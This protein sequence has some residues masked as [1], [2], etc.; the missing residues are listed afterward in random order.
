M[1]I[2]LMLALGLLGGFVAIIMVV[3]YINYAVVEPM[4]KRRVIQQRIRSSKKGKDFRTQI[5]K[6][7]Q[8]SSQGP[9]IAI[10][11]RLTGWSKAESLQRQLLQGDIYISPGVFIC[12]VGISGALG[13]LFSSK[14]QLGF[15]DPII[16]LAAGYVPFMLLHWKQKRKTAKFEKYMPDAME[17]LAR[18]LRA[19]HTL[20]ST[21]E[22][23]SQEI[24][25]PL[26]KEMRITY[27]E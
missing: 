12:V 6:A 26:G 1:N 22:L 5:F 18:S 17:L 10:I 27:E 15:W 20:P 4:R 9:V 21:L 25:A 7:Y 16:C 13:F 11:H 14:L 23:V 2:D 3:T 24:P 8:E 19:G